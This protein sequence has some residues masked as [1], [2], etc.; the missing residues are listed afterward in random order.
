M[1]MRDN[2]TQSPASVEERETDELDE[3]STVAVDGSYSSH[4]YDYFERLVYNIFGLSKSHVTNS[5]LETHSNNEK[6]KTKC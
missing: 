3:N 5:L 2:G 1:Y 4:M 6:N